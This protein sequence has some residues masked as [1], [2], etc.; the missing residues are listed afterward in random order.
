MSTIELIV[1]GLAVWRFSYMLINED[2]PFD[3]L[4][5]TRRLANRVNTISALFACIYCMSIWIAAA[6]LLLRAA[7][8]TVFEIIV[9]IGALSAIAIA[10]QHAIERLKHE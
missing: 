3:I 7:S 8:L 2:G 1:I 10:V 6:L 4:D 9:Y 5:H